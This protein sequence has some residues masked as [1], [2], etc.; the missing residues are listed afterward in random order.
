[1]KEI[2]DEKGPGEDIT[3]G[4]NHYASFI[5]AVRSRKPEDNPAPARV[6]HIASAH[7]HLGNI[8]YRLGATLTFDPAS[9]QFT[10]PDAA[11]ANPLL[12]REYREGFEVPQLA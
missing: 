6:G 1:N 2:P 8:A 5:H 4:G 12:K 11:K 7:C 3:V 10:G 9:E